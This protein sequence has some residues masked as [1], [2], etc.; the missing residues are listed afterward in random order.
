MVCKI[1]TYHVRRLSIN[2]LQRCRFQ[3]QTKSTLPPS[4]HPFPVCFLAILQK[5]DICLK[6]KG[7]SLWHSFN[8]KYYF[9]SGG[10]LEYWSL[11]QR[12][13]MRMLMVIHE[14][15]IELCSQ[16]LNQCKINQPLN[17]SI[18]YSVFGH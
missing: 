16:K 7:I 13:L 3:I 9:H 5:K 12:V 11:L 17:K 14:H 8:L 2:R 1:L 4:T 15:H 18:N 10:T 6:N